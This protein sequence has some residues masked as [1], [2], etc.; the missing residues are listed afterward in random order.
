[1]SAEPPC[2]HPDPSPRAADTI[3]ASSDDGADL[4]TGSTG[5]DLTEHGV[6][7]AAVEEE[8]LQRLGLPWFM[9]LAPFNTV[10]SSAI[11]GPSLELLTNV[12]CQAQ[13]SKSMAPTGLLFI[14]RAPE[15][16]GDP[17]PCAS[18]PSVQAG[19][20]ALLALMATTEGILSCI[21]TAWWGS[22]S[23]RYGRTTVLAF[24][25]VGYLIASLM[26]LAV[27]LVPESVPGGYW[28]LIYGSVLEGF[29][30]GRFTLPTTMQAY[31]SDCT[32]SASRSRIFSLY[33]GLHF[34]GQAFGPAI[35]GVVVH[36]YKR[37]VLVFYIAVAMNFTYAV[38]N[39][40]IVPESLLRAQMK[41]SRRK[42][43]E[44]LARRKSGFFSWLGKLFSFLSPI[45]IFAPVRVNR[46]ATPRRTTRRDWALTL[47]A[48]SFGLE[49]LVSGSAQY[50]FQYAIQTFGWSSGMVGYSLSIISMSRA[51]Y[52]SFF[53]PF[54]IRAFKH[55]LHPSESTNVPLTSA[56]SEPSSSPIRSS[57]K[58][59]PVVLVDFAIA[60]AS[61]LLTAIS[62]V[63]LGQAPNAWIF[64]G[65]TVL[66]SLGSGFM[67]TS[68]SLG[69]E[70]FIQG[71]GAE[72]GRLLG[73]FGVVQALG[74][75]V[76]GPSLFGYIYASTTATMPQ[77]MSFVFSGILL[78]SVG[79][80]GLVR[81]PAEE[82]HHD[83][84]DVA[85]NTPLL[86]GE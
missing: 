59:R 3:L 49:T 20:A 28:L 40:C 55:R 11:V 25:A 19:L 10:A 79:L 77:L 56:D 32:D 73:A 72:S 78:A 42:H 71:G 65:G 27:V 58:S 15:A 46:G 67:P 53:F 4:V 31:L 21:T 60:H 37:P 84:E 52:L 30:G 85:E 83:E 74:G 8:R 43:S 2:L 61:L 76:I 35:Y 39:C 63:V 86:S 29:V 26:V 6:E 36:V 47:L 62:F 81:V 44:E 12:V 69:L 7:L 9:V 16:L 22:L 50:W 48:L 68:N 18:D 24:N 34:S 23:D 1:M 57:S 13:R 66:M 38:A 64:I 45:G 14:K 51:V 80:L 82:A 5:Q 75:Q 41:I 17:M 33:M 54:I 70:L